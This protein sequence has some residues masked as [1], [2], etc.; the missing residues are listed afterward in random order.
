M[1]TI[2]VVA[3][4]IKKDQK[5]LIAERK[6]GEF[7]GLFEFPGGKVECGET[8]KEAII[9][10]IQEELE[11]TVSVESYFMNVK[12][13]YPTFTL[14]MDCFICTIENNN[15]K[16]NDHVS[17]RWITPNE[18]NIGWVPADIKVIDEIKERGI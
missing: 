16:L 9:R 11:V 10:E 13:D 14:D 8:G 7:A 15:I 17:I 6:K 5:I 1:N 18:N 2:K 12:Y 4:I 3:A